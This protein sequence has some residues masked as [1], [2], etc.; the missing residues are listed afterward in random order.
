M[1]N[2]IIA[3]K[4]EK[5]IREIENI[6][7]HHSDGNTEAI[8]ESIAFISSQISHIMKK[9]EKLENKITDMESRQKKIISILNSLKDIDLGE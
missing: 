3:S 9:Q 7:K 1:R 5:L 6:C 4:A 8:N 2:Q